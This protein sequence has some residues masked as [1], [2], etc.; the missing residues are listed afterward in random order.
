MKKLFLLL[1]ISP[2]MVRAQKRD[3]Y[4][5]GDS[6]LKVKDY[7]CAAANFEKQLEGDPESNG[8][9]FMLAKSWA[10]AGDKDKTFKALDLYVKNNALNNNP[11]F[12]EQLIKEKSFDFIKSDARWINMITSIQ[13]EEAKVRS[14]EKKE[15]DD[16]I[17]NWKAFE[18]AMDVR[19]QLKGMDTD[20][21][22][23]SKLKTKLVYRSPAPYLKDNGIALY[24]RVDATDV[25]FYVKVPANYDPAVAS[26]AM[27][28][29]H[30]AVRHSTG[31]G[32]PSWFPGIYQ[33]TSKFIPDY[34]GDYITV[35]P[36]G[37]KTINWMTTESGF[38]MVN[39]IVLQLKSYL[40]I[41]DNR[42]ELIGHS[43][44]ATGVF[45]Y[46]VKSPTLY[47]GFYGMNT[48]PKVY[49]G[50]TFL[51]NGRTR[52]FYNFATDKD[53]YYPPQAVKTIDSLANSLGVSW[54]T[55][56]NKGYP[57][58]FPSLPEAKALMAKIF[59]DMSAR[60]R[61]PYPKAIYFETDNTKYGTSDWI[62]ITAL[63][64]LSAK[65]VWQTEPNFKIDEWLDNNDFNKKIYRPAMAFD[66][67]HKSGAVK[68]RRE[69]NNIYVETSDVDSFSIR[70]SREMI[71]YKQKVNVFVNGKKVFSKMIKPDKQFTLSNF[72]KELDKKVIWENELGFKLSELRCVG[73]KE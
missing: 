34:A 51:Q 64:T 37:T 49:I 10:M 47:A 39:K 65:A 44:G 21:D 5:A 33:A 18:V 70:L 45:T 16:A 42:I 38:D 72:E 36:M 43:N 17:N 22:V 25:P 40:N 35:Y 58:W 62:S 7:A 59:M 52:Q 67:P 53:Y 41:D 60:L 6:C 28:V 27:V 9:A 50:G 29:L 2:A 23:Y 63:D 73:L 1:L 54:H 14:Q 4:A 30:G 57:H 8:T 71:D 3:Y 68:A 48:Q 19:P 11:F 15:N 32:K 13:K 66:Y 26:P 20:G 46:L 12:S 24:I 56:L 31:Y 61:N 69:G 55:E